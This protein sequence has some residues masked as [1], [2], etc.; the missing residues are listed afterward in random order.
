[1]ANNK[2]IPEQIHI[3]KIALFKS[4]IEVGPEV[5]SNIGHIKGYSISIAQDSGFNYEDKI[6]RLVQNISL[7]GKGVDENVLN[8]KGEF[9]VEIIF[10]IENFD[11]FVINE[12][13][14]KLIDGALGAT[15]SGIA[16][17]TF[18]GIILQETQNT[19]IG[20]V[21]IPVVDPSKMLVNTKKVKESGQNILS[22]KKP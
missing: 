17:S 3:K 19:A 2:I 10:H 1:M 4:K 20:G 12:D 13:E 11:S 9:G 6:V 22:T 7:E 5:L 8:V 16:Y 21:I 18:R 15:L 14:K